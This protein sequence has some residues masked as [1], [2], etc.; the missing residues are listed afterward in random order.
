[1][2]SDPTQ[3][4]SPNPTPPPAGKQRRRPAPG[5]GGNLAWMIIVILVVSYFF[6]SMVGPSG[7]IEWG[8]FYTLL[9]NDED[10]VKSGKGARHLKKVV[11][12]GNDRL[13]GEVHD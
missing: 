13:S 6:L 7:S 8:E 2:A 4:S 3:N 11:F 12:V 9:K 5:A 1:M 10:V